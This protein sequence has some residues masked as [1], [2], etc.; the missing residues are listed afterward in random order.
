MKKLSTVKGKQSGIAAIEFMVAAPL[1]IVIVFAVTEFAWAFHQYHTMTR[2]TRD[3]ARHMASGAL[4]GSVGMIYLDTSLVQE[5]GNLVVYGNTTGAGDPLLPRW[6]RADVTVTSPDASHI[7]VS[8]FYNYVPLVGRIPAFYGGTPLSL[9]F[10]M[11][12][13]V[14][15][16]A[17]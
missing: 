14:E 3:G 9:S 10:Q 12:S 2:A 8:A 6:T 17:L 4:I 7:R 5:T 16:R 1:L 13:T 15:M 11:Q